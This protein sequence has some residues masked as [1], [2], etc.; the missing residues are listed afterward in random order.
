MV[1]LHST[2]AGVACSVCD[3][4]REV[5]RSGRDVAHKQRE[6]VTSPELVKFT[7]DSGWKHITL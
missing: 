7:D 1:Q 4:G 2:S 5:D 6:E 3:E